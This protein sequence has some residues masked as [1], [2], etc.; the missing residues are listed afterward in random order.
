MWLTVITWFYIYIYSIF[1]RHMIVT[2]TRLFTRLVILLGYTPRHLLF[3]TVVLL[4]LYPY[5]YS[6]CCYSVAYVS[7]YLIILY[8]QLFFFFFMHLVYMHEF[9]PLHTHSLGRFLTTL[10]LHVQILDAC[11]FC[12][13]VRWDYTLCE[14]LE[15]LPFDSGILAFSLFLLL[16]FDSCISPLASILFLTSFQIMC[17]LYM[18]YC[19]DPWL[20][21]FRFI[22]CSGNFRL[23]A[24]TWGIFLAYMR[25]RLVLRLRSSVF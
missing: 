7:Y 17:S 19:S 22:A 2:R 24:Y 13:G 6:C 14:E 10:D 15:A 9:S 20:L 16:F 5:S 8:L 25:R 1:D 12:A 4:V 3:V 23:S 18:Y 11:F 21:W